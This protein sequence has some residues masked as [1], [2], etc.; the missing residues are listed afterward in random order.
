MKIFQTI[1]AYSSFAKQFNL[2]AKE[3]GVKSFAGL[4]ALLETTGYCYPHI[5]KPLEADQIFLHSPELATLSDA[6]KTKYGMKQKT[7]PDEIL[8]SQIEE[9]KADI[10]Y[11]QNPARFDTNFLKKMPTSVQHKLCW[12]SSHIP[13]EKLVGYDCVLTSFEDYATYLTKRGINTKLAFPSVASPKSYKKSISLRD[14]QF[15]FSGGWSRRHRS[16]NKTLEIFAEKHSDRLSLLLDTSNR[17]SWLQKINLS[18]NPFFVPS[19]CRQM[20]LGAK[21]GFE[22]IEELSK[23]RFVFNQAIDIAPLDRGNIRC[24]EAL[25]AGSLLISDNGKYPPGFEDGENYLAYAN[26]DDLFQLIKKIITEPEAYEHI[27]DSGRSM[28]TDTYS[29]KRQYQNFLSAL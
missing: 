3:K 11:F 28:V 23:H 4:Q 27:A 15:V 1:F 18:I 21:F 29:K 14:G 8:L 7:N 9:Q 6:W 20:N 19:I 26:I 10:V 5:L 12:S 24:F 17:F 22:M 16:R 25:T 2:K 13:A